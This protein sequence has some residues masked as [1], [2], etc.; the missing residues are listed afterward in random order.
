MGRS[1]RDVRLLSHPPRTLR[2]VAVRAEAVPYGAAA[3]ERLAERVREA[4]GVTALAGVTVVVPS[5]YAGWRLAGPWPP[6][7]AASPTSRS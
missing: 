3:M 6:N 4:K 1:G 7:P 2:A 5:N